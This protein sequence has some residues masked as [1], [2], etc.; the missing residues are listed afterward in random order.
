[1][2]LKYLYLYLDKVPCCM[3]FLVGSVPNFR[4]PAMFN[5][6]SVPKQ[7]AEHHAVEIFW[8]Y[9]KNLGAGT[10][11]KCKIEKTQVASSIQ[12]IDLVPGSCAPQ[13]VVAPL[14]H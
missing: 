9:P 1:M 6:P 2:L 5:K 14:S 10:T 8:P 12:E 13:P 11:Q 3:L 7:Y 4:D